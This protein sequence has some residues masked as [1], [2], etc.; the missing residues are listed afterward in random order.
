MAITTETLA[1]NTSQTLTTPTSDTGK[2]KVRFKCNAPSAVLEI[3]VS[4]TSVASITSGGTYEIG[5]STTSYTTL[6]SAA[7]DYSE[8]KNPDGTDMYPATLA[9]EPIEASAVVVFEGG[10]CNAEQDYKVE[11]LE[12]GTVY[13]LTFTPTERDAQSAI[14]EVRVG[15]ADDGL[16]RP[17][18]F[19]CGKGE[20]H[21]T[22][23]AGTL[24]FRINGRTD[25]TYQVECLAKVITTSAPKSSVTT[26]N[27]TAGG[28]GTLPVKAGHSYMVTVA[29]VPTSAVTVAYG[30]LVLAT[31]S[32]AGQATIIAPADAD[33]TV[34]YPAGCSVEVTEVFR[35]APTAGGGLSSPELVK[36]TDSTVSFDD[37]TG[38]LTITNPKGNAIYDIAS[39]ASS[40]SITVNG[41]TLAGTCPSGTTDTEIRFNGSADTTTPMALTIPSNYA[42][43][44]TEIITPVLGKFHRICFR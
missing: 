15:E 23:T 5:I 42:T 17:V 9:I 41:I 11:G 26:F 44:M 13:A 8:F 19:K 12:V 3:K 18:K 30:D 43:F 24:Y 7:H 28:T 6:V 40:S 14:M 39:L 1:Y 35:S 4:G 38:V 22:A 16:S 31:L 29:S 25:V 10:T 20:T 27:V 34:T 36:A 33:L 32:D 2:F 37:T 21:F